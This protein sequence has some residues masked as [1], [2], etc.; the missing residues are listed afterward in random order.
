MTTIR[1]KKIEIPPLGVHLTLCAKI[2]GMSTNLVLD[3]GASRSVVDLDYLV[4]LIPE[5]NLAEE[6]MNSAGVGSDSLQCF[7][8]TLDLLELDDFKINQ[9]EIAVMDLTH[10]KTSYLQLGAEAVFGVIGGDVLTQYNAL[11]DYSA[12]TLTLGSND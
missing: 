3:T 4:E 12:L 7:T 9:F 5:I 1:L 8:S 11:I 6:T 2:N 10:V